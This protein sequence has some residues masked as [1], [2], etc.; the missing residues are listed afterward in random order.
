MGKVGFRVIAGLFLCIAVAFADGE[1]APAIARLSA[2]PAI[3][4]LRGCGA[5]HGLLVSAD[6]D[7][8]RRLDVTREATIVSSDP[9]IIAVVDGRL[10]A[11]A[12]GEVEVTVTHAG[13][14]A[15]IRAVATGA[16][17]AT[18]P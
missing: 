12:D 1:S 8:G 2:E 11:L 10:V 15:K 4:E 13:Q 7:D 17:V 14:S 18:P 9:K 6:A 3:V 5:E 16:G